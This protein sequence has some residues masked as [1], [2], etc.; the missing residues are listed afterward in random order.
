MFLGDQLDATQKGRKS[1]AAETSETITGQDPA[2]REE[3][4]FQQQ[5]LGDLLELSGKLSEPQ[6]L[7]QSHAS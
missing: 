1:L 3:S 5:S 2:R 7:L 6:L 4:R